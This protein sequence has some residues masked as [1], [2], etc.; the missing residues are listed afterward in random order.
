MKRLCLALAVAALLLLV[1]GVGTATANPPELQDAGQLVGSA[2]EAAGAAGT[3]QQ[4]PTNDS[5]GASDYSPSDDG[6]SVDQSNDA[7]SDATAGNLNATKQDADQEQEGSGIQAI[8]QK[9]D[10]EQDAL[11]L[12]FTLQEKPENT[13]VPVSVLGKGDGGDV[14]QSNDASSEAN[15]GNLNLTSQEA[16]QNQGS[17]DGHDLTGLEAEHDQKPVDEHDCKCE[18]GGT[19]AIGQSADSDQKA[20]AAAKTVQVK[21]SNTNISVRVLSPGDDGDVTQTNTASSDATAFNL[22]ATKQD[23]DQKQDGSCKCTGGEQAIGQTADSDQ[24]A[25]ALA[26]TAQVKPSNTNISVR[27]LSYGDD[28]DVT[29]SN[30]A[31][32]DAKA[33]NINLTKQDADQKQDGSGIQGIGQSA[34]SDQKALAASTTAQEKPSNKNISVRVLSPGDGG[35]VTQSNT[36]SSD[37]TAFNVNAT[38]QDADQKQ[39]GDSCKCTGGEQAIGQSAES[40][41]DAKALAATFQVK[42]S[43]TNTS[44]RVLSKGDDGDVTQ[45]NDASSSAFAGNLNLTKQDADQ[46]QDGGSGT[47]AIGQFAKNE[48][49]AKALAATFQ[50]KPSNTNTSVRVL[51]KGEGGDVTQ[52]N[53]ASSSA[54]AGNANLTKQDA[55]QKQDGDSC[56]CT[57]GEQAIGQ[58]AKNDQD[59]KALA[60]TFQ[61]K[62]SNTNTPVRVLSKGDDG[63]VTQTNDASSSAFAG[64]LNLTKQDADQK[65]DG[66]SG[67]QAIGQFAKNDQD[68]FALA[69][70]FQ[71]G[72]SNENTPVRIGSKGDSG[73]VTQ[74][75][76]A[77]SAAVAANLNFLEQDADQKQGGGRHDEHDCCGIGIQAIGQFAKNDQKAVALAATF[78]VFK[79]PCVCGHGGSAGNSNTPVDVGS[80][81]DSGDVTQSNTASSL[82]K[83]FNVNLTKQDADQ[84]QDTSCKC[85]EALGIQAIGQL[86]ESDQF[87]A[88]L[89]ATFQLGASNTSAPV[90]I[91]HQKPHGDDKD[92]AR[93]QVMPSTE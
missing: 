68:A 40:E 51:S 19:Q 13:N 38:K 36:A 27:V 84:K 24:K 22:N 16:E 44:V 26:D 20:V 93:E 64:N 5:S 2:Q 69:T 30:T 74:S 72:A 10:S 6:G 34:D 37:A 86:N 59:A 33:G 81:G 66:G 88:A 39:D 49:D 50:V 54:F 17:G 75:N 91:D 25:V 63:D 23:A 71:I 90:R 87:S 76:T 83:A 73:D 77:T 57:G 62:P 58:F 55:D 15:A 78:Q 28:G 21:P 3:A 41:Q 85:E 82:A 67:I 79:Q 32:S 47:Q 80:K 89:A 70:T 9:A 18:G 56:K 46:K 45:T 31:T 60:A 48:Q 61:V 43:N 52:T 12:A 53:D 4:E 35:S 11:A 65:Q 7:T 1:A 92:H 29:Q 14:T 8:G 42:P